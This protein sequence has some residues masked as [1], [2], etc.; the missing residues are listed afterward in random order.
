[1]GEGMGKDNSTHNQQ[2]L[3]VQTQKTGVLQKVGCD[4]DVCDQNK[5]QKA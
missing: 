1:M 2:F 5:K 3:I 4:K